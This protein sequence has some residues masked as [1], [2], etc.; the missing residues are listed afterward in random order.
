MSDQVKE[1]IQKIDSLEKQINLVQNNVNFSLGLTWAIL[2]VIIAATG[3][4]LYFLVKILVNKRVED[5]LKIIKKDIIDKFQKIDYGVFTDTST[6]VPASKTYV[7]TI[8]LKFNPDR[9][10]L[11]FSC[12]SNPQKWQEV[13]I[14]SNRY[15]L[16]QFNYGK[17]RGTTHLDTE[18]IFFDSLSTEVVFGMGI[19]I[20]NVYVKDKNICVVF[21]NLSEIIGS[22][23]NIVIKWEAEK[24]SEFSNIEKF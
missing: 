16:S 15:T 5:E 18:N 14:L 2:S 1:L 21:K 7:K 8:P 12:Y 17:L 24:S 19:I 9:V 13:E 20:E 6:N 4:S 3:V 23:L 22:T 10:K 11:N